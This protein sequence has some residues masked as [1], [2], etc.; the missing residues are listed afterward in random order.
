APA[1][2]AVR[3]C[4]GSAAISLF[5]ARSPAPRQSL[6]TTS[7]PDPAKSTSCGTALELSSI[8]LLRDAALRVAPHCQT[9]NPHDPSTPV[10]SRF[11][12]CPVLPIPL[13]Q[14][15]SLSPCGGT[16]SVVGS[17]LHAARSGKS[18]S[19]GSNHHENA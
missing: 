12:R 9:A 19:S 13:A 16:T 18:T 3:L 5:P 14:S 1:V 7:L 6:H 10:A 8:L 4:L 11:H 2:A 15:T 17:R